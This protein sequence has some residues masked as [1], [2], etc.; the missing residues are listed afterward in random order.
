LAANGAGPCHHVAM[1]PTPATPRPPIGFAHRGAKA[2]ARE[3]T[4]EAFELALELGATGLESDVWVTR[5]GI[6][7][8]DHDGD[9]RRRTLFRTPIAEIDRAELPDHI[10]TLQGLYD[11]CGVDFELS[12]DI[13]TDAAFSEV[14]AVA[15]RSGAE[16]KLWL[17]HHDWQAVA[18]WRAQTNAKLVDSTR[19]RHMKEGPE[20]RAANLAAAGIDAVN[21]HHSDWS[22]GLAVLFHRFEL[23]CL[24]WDAQ[25]ARVLAN[26]VRMSLDGVY[27]DH[28]APMMA[29]IS[30]V[31]PDVTQ[32]AKEPGED[33]SEPADIG[34]GPNT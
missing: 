11:T 7:V 9:V 28:V 6:A 21:M 4:I 31:W 33:L 25:H 18:G 8:L 14:I 24:G 3:N 15:R 1:S 2:L 19:L 27:S 23:F 29:A 32:N 30:A 34:D 17:C 5:D 12:L 20:R 26:M 22:G 10:P 16:D 13:K